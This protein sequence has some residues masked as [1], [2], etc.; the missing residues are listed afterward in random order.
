ML[1]FKQIRQDKKNYSKGISDDI[2]LCCIYL[3]LG[4][5]ESTT[6]KISKLNYEIELEKSK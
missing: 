3:Y 6:E 4:Y 1:V 5:L 2:K